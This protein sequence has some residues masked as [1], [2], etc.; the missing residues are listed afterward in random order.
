MTT[1]ANGPIGSVCI[2]MLSAIGDAVHV[3]PVA[4]ALKRAWPDV[5]ISWIIQPTLRALVEGHAAIDELIV[6]ERRRGGLR[7]WTNFADLGHYVRGKHFDLVLALQVYLKAGI[8]VGMLPAKRKLG[9]DTARARDAN[10]IFTNE[11]IPPQPPQHV[12][13]QYFEFLHYL[14]V[15]PEPVEWDI[16]IA[17]Q[18]REAQASFFSE[19][20]KP[21]CSVVVA[22][23]KPRKNWTAEGYARILEEIEST[24]GLQPILVGGPSKLEREMADEILSLTKAHPI[25]AIGDDL[26]RLVYLLDGSA[27]TVSPDTGPL[28]I[29]RALETPVVGIYGCTN[30]KRSGPYRR[31]YDLVVDGYAEFPGEEYPISMDQRNGMKRVTAEMVLEKVDLAVRNYL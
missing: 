16:P 25:D 12:Q 3:L 21:A 28:H 31:Y 17:D 11:R 5:R 30:P 20:D 13:A 27:L 14:G 26:R 29:S 8:V 10:W 22:T 1:Q 24:H 7:S 19:L 9:F 6:F 23:T 18:D 4:N 15:D 2:V